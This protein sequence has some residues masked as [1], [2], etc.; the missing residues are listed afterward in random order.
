MFKFSTIKKLFQSHSINTLRET[1][2]SENEDL[3][4]HNFDELLQ[5]FP[6][7]QTVLRRRFSENFYKCLD[8][9]RRPR[10]VK[11]NGELN[12]H[13][14]NVHKHRRRLW[15]DIFNTILDVKWRWHFVFFFFSFIV[16]WFLFAT[17]WYMI[18][19]LHGDLVA[20]S[21][22][23][24]TGSNSSLPQTTPLHVDEHIEEK[25]VC[26]HGMFF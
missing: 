20:K 3:D 14:E 15:S 1:S 9:H 10:L 6:N 2:A 8:V 23:S 24:F 25:K 5:F 16:S 26:V 18:A 17:I 21:T 19:F 4:K 7:Q 12:M 11:K 22:P 13:T